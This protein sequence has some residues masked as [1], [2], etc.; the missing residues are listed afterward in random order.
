MKLNNL[1][2][3]LVLAA[4]SLGAHAASTYRITSGNQV[5]AIQLLQDD[6]VH[7]EWSANNAPQ[8][9][10]IPSTPMVARTDYAGITTPTGGNVLKTKTLNLQV[11][12]SNLCIDVT[13]IRQ[14]PAYRL[15]RLCP[16]DLTNKEMTLS[17]SRESFHHVYGLGQQH[18]EPG[19]IDGD[20]SGKS[21]KPGSSFGNALVAQGGGA[22]ANT[23][24]PIAYMLGQGKQN[25]ALFVDSPYAQSWDLSRDPYTVKS[26]GEALRVY[27]IGGEDL[28]SLRSTYLDL[29]G[30]P[31]VPPKKAFGMWLSEYGFDNWQELE[32]KLN[33]LRRN[34]FPVDGAFLD[35]QWFGGVTANSD[36]TKMGSMRWDSGNFA[37]AEAKLKQL[38]DKSGI[39]IGLIEQPYIG[40]RLPEYLTLSTKGYLV[41]QCPY[42]CDPIYLQD[43]PWWGKG[44]MLDFSNREGADFWHD[45]RRETLVKAGVNYHWTDLGEPAM[46][47]TNGWY[48]GVAIGRGSANTHAAVHNLYNLLWS[49]SIAEGYKRNGHKN[50]PFQLSRSGSAGSQR[51]GVAMWSGEIGSDLTNLAAHL[52]AQMH[53][54]LS[55]IDYFGSDVGGFRREALKGDL[56]DTYTQWFAASAMLDVPLR[57]HVE[58]LS[59][60]NQS[61]PDKVGNLASNLANLRLRYELAPY[62]YSLAHTAW[63]TGEAVVSPLVYHFQSDPGTRALGSQKMIGKDLLV[64]VVAKANARD[65]MVYLPEGEWYDYHSDK[66]Y[67]SAGEWVGPIPLYHDGIYRLPLFARQGA[68]IPGQYVDDQT[69]TVDGQKANGTLE[70]NLL[71]RIYPQDGKHKMT[72]IED[73]GETTDYQKKESMETDI[74]VKQ[75]DGRTELVIHNPRGRYN[76]MPVSRVNRVVLV[77]QAPINNVTLNGKPLPEMSSESALNNSESG[78]YKTPT[79]VLV[80][81][82]AIRLSDVKEID[83][84][85]ASASPASAPAS[86]SG[87][88]ASAAVAPVVAGGTVIAALGQYASISSDAGSQ[89]LIYADGAYHATLQLKAGKHQL[90]ITP[91]DP[92]KQAFGYKDLVISAGVPHFP[93]ADGSIGVEISSAANYQLSLISQGSNKPLLTLAPA[94]FT[95]GPIIYLRSS[96]NGWGV[97]E[98][99]VQTGP[100]SYE[101][102]GAVDGRI[103]YKLATQDYRGA[104]FGGGRVLT[105]ANSM[106]LGN[107]P[108]VGNAIID[109]P[110]GN[111]RLSIHISGKEAVVRISPL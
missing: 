1:P 98:P 70:S 77:T 61:A 5:L 7:I 21:R 74:D 29:T 51:Y 81:T 23:Q 9:P 17:F 62:Y 110:P 109:V 34:K 100:N 2:V 27:L 46:Y 54:S 53:M 59:N 19:T 44:S 64:A 41:R 13:D 22:V 11:D 94:T 80:K 111:Y 58:N 56:N 12:G 65:T 50:R 93:A 105:T 90:R 52:N 96:T 63:R 60:S 89:P 40:R 66:R 79:R 71:L 69:L 95:P 30:R 32:D 36:N 39:A 107:R 24:I 14:Q 67:K 48:A 16:A 68:M 18:P 101:W 49:R 91:D 84:I 108:G 92:T 20:W 45:W 73:D 87:A 104:N 26:A 76:R 15:T 57:P 83:F 4:A 8:Q 35:L 42:P 78:W 72:M 37:N 38:R 97:T 3:F 47:D 25:Y 82:P 88:K 86:S 6:L 85:P 102:T 28:P 75:K 33:S 31:P 106:T 99:L 55:G 43:N 103:E 10:L